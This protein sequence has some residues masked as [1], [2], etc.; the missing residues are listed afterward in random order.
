MQHFSHNQIT[1]SQF[2]ICLFLSYLQQVLEILLYVVLNFWL[3]E[4]GDIRVFYRSRA[5]VQEE[6]PSIEMEEFHRIP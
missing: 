1:G 6:D 5:E 2:V 3:K 4:N